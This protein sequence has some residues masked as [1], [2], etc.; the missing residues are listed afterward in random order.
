M[1]FRRR[2]GYNPSWNPGASLPDALTKGDLAMLRI[3]LLGVPVLAS[4]VVLV[5]QVGLTQEPNK[6]PSKEPDK[7][8]SKEQGKDPQ[9]PPE[10]ALQPAQIRVI[11]PPEAT[12]TIDKYETKQTGGER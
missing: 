3:R 9:K 12:L 2:H 7:Q 8:P 1:P 4:L 5:A 6:Q 10:P 11:L